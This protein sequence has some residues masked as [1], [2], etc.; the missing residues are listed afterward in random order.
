MD[1]KSLARKTSC[2]S[3]PKLSL[4][5]E[6]LASTNRRSYCHTAE[7]L[8]HTAEPL[9]RWLEIPKKDNVKTKW[10]IY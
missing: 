10:K 3:S 7:R 2:K 9:S 4:P 1:S 6:A 8:Q 5:G